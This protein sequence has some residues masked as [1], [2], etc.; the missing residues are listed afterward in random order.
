MVTPHSSPENHKSSSRINITHPKFTYRMRTTMSQN[1][2]QI[3]S[4]EFQKFKQTHSNSSNLIQ[5]QIPKS[6]PYWLKLQQ[7]SHHSAAVTRD[8]F[9]I[10]KRKSARCKI[11]RHK[12]IAV[13]LT[14]KPVQVQDSRYPKNPQYKF[15]YQNI[16]HTGINFSI[17]LTINS[18]AP[19]HG[20]A[21]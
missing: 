14:S 12:F 16:N 20:S 5:I 17:S 19:D 3:Q 15:K 7:S 8:P 4:T 18:T 11:G 1:L 21:V 6:K 13:V 2:K 10:I 9:S